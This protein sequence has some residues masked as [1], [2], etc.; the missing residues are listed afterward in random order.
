MKLR[1]KYSILP[2]ILL[3]CAGLLFSG[4][5][6]AQ[7]AMCK[8]VVENGD[9]GFSNGINN[10]ILYLMGVPYIL[11]FI[12]FRTRLINFFKEFGALYKVKSYSMR[13]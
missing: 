3:L 12:L 1:L 6:D 4:T 2:A 7:C 9:S 10:G 5:A 13:G 11:L 8:A